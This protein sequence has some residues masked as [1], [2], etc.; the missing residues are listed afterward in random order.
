MCLIREIHP[1]CAELR[2]LQE[3]D[4]DSDITNI[5]L[6]SKNV[7]LSLC[8][9]MCVCV[10]VCLC[11]HVCVCVR[12]CV[13]ASECVCVCVVCVCVRAPFFQSKSKSAL[14]SIL[15]HVPYIHTEN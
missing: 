3:P 15:P 11:A 5:G 12:A 7:S 4:C 9:C 1:N 8:V 14:L 6:E 2:C 10:C 13:R